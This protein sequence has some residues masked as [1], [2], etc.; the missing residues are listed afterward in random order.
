M[1]KRRG[2]GL[3]SMDY[4]TKSLAF[5]LQKTARYVRLYGPSRTLVKVRG[6]YH[7]R[8]RFDQLP[9]N[10]NGGNS[11]AN[12]GIIGC[13]NY[14]FT[15]IA[16]YLR[17]TYGS[18]IHGCMDID[19]NR[20]ASL[21][22]AYGAHF[23]TTSAADIIRDPTIK[24]VYIASNHASH[25][26]YAIEALLAGKDV[27]IEKPHAISEEQL[28]RL[29]SAQR[30]TT[31]R[32]VSIGY[33][34]PV[35]PFGMAIREA[36]WH[37][38][39]PLMQNWFVAGHEIPPAHW[40]NRPEEGGRVP[41]NLCHWIDF[42][43]QV[44]PPERRWPVKIIPAST[45]AQDGDMAVTFIFGD[46]SMA[47]IAFSVKGHAFEGVRE[48]Y[49]AHRGDVLVSLDDFN[50]LVIDRGVKKTKS[51][52]L[53]RNHGHSRSVCR[54]YEIAASNAERGCEHEYVMNLGLLFLKTKLALET[55]SPIT[56]ATC[57]NTG[58]R[59]EAERSG[60]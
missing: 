45:S 2:N 27:H 9:P 49:T 41:G 42:I 40:Y 30:A 1:P 57:V 25:A 17:R 18:V 10:R 8:R 13:G 59:S 32:I 44:M 34:R 51:V 47:S 19:I 5:R 55:S 39:G 3:Q 15:V 29:C 11:T 33:N 60:M 23:Y 54:S 21:A 20:A 43:Y 35:S 38:E 22:Q 37:E 6:N 48:R 50:Q 12:V 31:G 36:I 52:R 46:G 58:S 28:Q 14:A 53:F 56:L 26:E 4:T 7:M 16:Y 24:L